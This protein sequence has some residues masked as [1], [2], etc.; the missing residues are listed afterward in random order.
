MKKWL[1]NGLIVLCLTLA[2]QGA[3]FADQYYNIK[4]YDVK[5]DVAEDNTY[6]IYETIDVFFNQARHGIY[7]DIPI[8]NYGYSH[9]ISDLKVYNPFT[10]QSIPFEGS[11]SGSELSVKIGDPDVYVA[12][13]QT[14]RI[15]YTYEGGDD[16]IQDYDEFYFNLIGNGWDATIDSVTFRV[17]M[18]KSFD[19]SNLNVTVG[20]AGS[21]DNARATWEVEGNVIT[22]ES[23]GLS[24]FEGL[25]I[26]LTLPQGYYVDVSEPYSMI[27]IF[28]LYGFLILTLI[29]AIIIRNGNFKRSQIVPV[30][31]FYPPDDL[32]PAEMAYV[33]GEE[34]L[35]N[36]N[37]ASL[38]VYW[39]SKGY[40]RI[41]EDEK[42]GLFGNKEEV[43]FERLVE[44]SEVPSGY[45]Q[46][47]FIELFGYGYGNTVHIDDLK[48]KFYED[49]NASREFI[50]DRYRDEHEILENKTQY[51]AGLIAF[52]VMAISTLLLTP[53]VQ[54]ILGVPFVGAL[55]PTAVVLLIL[56]LIPY[57]IASRRPGK[58]KA[59]KGIRIT[60]TIFTVV[61][62][63]QSLIM[64][65]VMFRDFK[66][67]E[68]SFS[69]LMVYPLLA[70]VL[71]IVVMYS[72]GK[73]KRYT[74]FAQDLLNRIHGFKNF[75]ETAKLDK[76]HML[77]EENSEY[78]YD[79]LPYVM[80]FGSTEIWDEYM[81]MIAV[82][83]PNWYVSNRPFRAYYMM[84]T[85]SHSFAQMSSTPQ[86]SSSGGGSVGGG[87][88]GGGGGSW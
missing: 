64:S 20:R 54:V 77:F 61:F 65:R 17:T 53:Y 43:Y 19:S 45:E 26:A 4:N 78:F 84:N 42:P 30:L 14:Y 58:R 85:V 6:V 66:W 39:A 68:I 7:R 55:I 86:K 62:F 47:L 29:G 2:F 70:L 52:L 36:E 40:L 15:E 87:G 83:G 16:R 82:S 44:A 56:L 32:N 88:G 50:R 1:F 37:V 75:L 23:F 8:R 74:L 79:M 18:P 48:E 63:S 46:T 34:Q 28:L 76:L 22:G 3:A 11:Q 13:D 51:G 80:I 31:S 60:R 71:Y 10:S 27:W 12:G 38:I 24:P 69:S 59:K 41:V 33:F 67:S 73:V 21:T 57:A 35:S 81:R 49:L 9:K 5:I 72:I 25:T